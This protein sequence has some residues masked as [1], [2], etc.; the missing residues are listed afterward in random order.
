MEKKIT[1]TF[2]YHKVEIVD[3]STKAILKSETITTEPDRKKIAIKFI[4]E[5]GN[6]NFLIN[7][8]KTEELRE[9]TLETFIA[10]STIVIPKEKTEDVKTDTQPTNEGG[11]K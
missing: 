8:T 10:N 2:N 3:A 1:R 4:K 7:I 5:S 11:T 9:M 6:T